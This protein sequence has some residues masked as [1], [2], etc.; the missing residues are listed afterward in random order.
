MEALEILTA[1]DMPRAQRN[2]RSAICLLALTDVTP[3]K[4]W[5][6]A[7]MPLIGITPIMEFAGEHYLPSPYAPNTR[8]TVR[9]Q[10]MHQFCDAGIAVYNPDKPGRAV[11]S[12]DAAYQISPEALSLVRAFGSPQWPEALALF[13]KQR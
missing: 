13:N 5:S 6:E 3:S 4:T 9:R 8:E 10:S 11:N 1:I 12:P 2:R 7:A